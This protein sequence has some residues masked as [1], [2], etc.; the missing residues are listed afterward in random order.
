MPISLHP[1]RRAILKAL[2]LLGIGTATFGRALTALAQDRSE[3]TTD[4][5]ARAE[6]VAGVSFTDEERDLML[7]GVNEA[8]A[9]FDLLRSANIDNAVPPAMSPTP[10]GVLAADSPARTRDV[11]NARTDVTPRSRA[12]DRPSADELP[13]LTVG[14][15]GSLLR[16]GLLRSR[17]LTELYLERLK[18]YDETLECVITLT[19]ARALAQAD[20]ADRELSDGRDRGPLHGIPWGAKDIIAVAGYPTTWGA[21]PYRERVI[22]NTATVVRRLDEAGAVLLAK[23][24]VGALAWGDVWFDG[25]TKNPWHVEEGSSGSSA[26]SASATAAGLVGFALGSETWGSIVSPCT[27]CG[28]SGLRPT[29]GRV[30][31]AGVMALSWSM[32]KVG[33]IARSAED[34]SLVFGAIHGA[35]AGDAATVDRP[36][37]WP[38]AEPLAGLRIGVASSLFEGDRE[39]EFGEEEPDGADAMRATAKE[40]ADFDRRSLTELEAAGATLVPVELPTDLPT[41]AMGHILTAEA[42]AAF[43]ELSRSGRDDELVR[44]IE[45]AWPNVFRQGQLIPAVSY[46]QANRMRTLLMRAYDEALRDVDMFVAPSYEGDHMLATNLT[47]HPAVVVPNGY[48]ASN[49]TPTSITFTGKLYEDDTLLMVADAFQRATGYHRA[50]PTL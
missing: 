47:G 10:V 17:E 49:G 43:D 1:T 41:S 32:D 23:L 42:A 24:T 15:L 40:W 3:I 11:D 4:M 2:G 18:R 25:V 38:A 22:D 50:H 27:R 28:C 36:F 45:F 30:S 16:R 35:D 46:I 8:L 21:T 9:D 26:G 33:P 6:W 12:I 14:D 37:A 29:F 5:L 44:Q 48:R 34:L 7:R 19:E 39:P 13:F 31:R 20:A